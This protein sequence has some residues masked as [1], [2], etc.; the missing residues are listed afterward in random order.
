MVFA[1]L[2]SQDLWSGFSQYTSLRPLRIAA[3]SSP[4]SCHHSSQDSL[5]YPTV[6]S[7]TLTYPFFSF[8]F[9]KVSIMVII[10]IIIN[11]K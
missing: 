7:V 2:Q 8:I 3:I 6:Y 11:A 1:V 4:V 5:E 9:P 10:I